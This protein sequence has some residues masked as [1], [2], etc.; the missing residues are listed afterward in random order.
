MKLDGI[1]DGLANS[2]RLATLREYHNI[3]IGKVNH[4]DSL[5]QRN[6][7]IALVIFA[8]LSGFGTKSLG[9]LPSLFTALG[10]TILMG[11]FCLLDRRLHRMSHGW[12]DT[13]HGVLTALGQ[14]TNRPADIVE[15]SRYIGEAEDKAELW[16]LQPVLYYLLIVISGLSFFA[17]LVIGDAGAP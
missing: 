15:F 4:L 16:S 6:M 5:R 3:C 17:F 9:V 1:K 8:V 13:G 11:T 14:A 12:R 10:L 2:D 7:S